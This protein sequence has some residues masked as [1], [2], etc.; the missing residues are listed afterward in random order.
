MKDLTAA[1]NISRRN[2]PRIGRILD[3]PTPVRIALNDVPVQFDSA[4]QVRNGATL[5]AFRQVYEQAGGRVKWNAAR[6]EVR[7]TGGGATIVVHIGSR[8]VLVNG[9]KQMLDAPAFIEDGRTFLPIR[10]V[11]DA[12]GL[13]T[14][15]DAPTGSITLNSATRPEPKLA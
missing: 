12:L 10:F 6:R 14:H 5:A 7:A 4:P 13:A 8:E 9:H 2:P 11:A 3:V 15:Y 1:N